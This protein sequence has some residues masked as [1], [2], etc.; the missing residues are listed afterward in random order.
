MLVAQLLQSSENPYGT[1]SKN[2]EVGAMRPCHKELMDLR[3]EQLI[4]SIAHQL[5]FLIAYQLNW[6]NSLPA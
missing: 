4:S 1:E 5:I 2:S 6:L 3:A